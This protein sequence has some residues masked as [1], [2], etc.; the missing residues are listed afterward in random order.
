MQNLFQLKKM[1]Q[2]GSM[3]L[4][5]P[6]LII[7]ILIAAA[8]DFY[9]LTSGKAAT[10]WNGALQLGLDH[11][12]C[13]TNMNNATASVD[14][15]SG[16]MSKMQ[17]WMG[18]PVGKGGKFQIKTLGSS[19]CVSAAGGDK[20]PVKVMTCSTS[21]KTQLWTWANAGKAATMNA[22]E[23]MNTGSKMCITDPGDS[24]VPGMALVVSDCKANKPNQQWLKSKVPA[25]APSYSFT[26]MNNPKDTT[27]NQL[28][29]INNAGLIVGYYGSGDKG[30]PNKGYTIQ[31][32]T[33]KFVDENYP[34]AVQTQVTGL[35]NKGF[36]VGFWSSMNTA[37]NTNNNFGFLTNQGKFYS[38]N[39]PA[40]APA[41]PPVDQLLGIND[42]NVAAGFYTD[43]AGN[44]H[45]YEFNATNHHYSSVVNSAAKNASLTAAAIN[46]AS[47]VAG[48]W[49]NPK[50]GK[51]DAFLLMRQGNKFI[52]LA[53]PGASSTM[54][55]GVNN[56][57]EVVGFY[58]VG[59]GDN[60]PTHGFIWTQ[61]G[62]FQTI[63]APDGKDATTINGLND[64]GQ[65]VGFYT[66]AKGN[67]DGFLAA[68]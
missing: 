11:N 3:H 2:R 54:A 40:T 18:V 60:A 58:T 55:L 1:T 49:D 37:D 66:D 5:M 21:D 36:T 30:H 24:K 20:A 52:D 22:N 44:N 13:M 47:D 56:N 43:A 4:V 67:T 19:M 42:T 28:L 68:P 53:A 63:D 6:V 50:S 31:A 25:G 12:L 23:L 33:T 17:N 41:A 16:A 51:T 15:C 65:L 8:G 61:D 32:G 38:V 57:D 35:N 34:G 14:L 39:Y 27:F 45:G 64:N 29:G 62:G 48:F 9:L 46:N 59:D 10:P 7:L 26:T